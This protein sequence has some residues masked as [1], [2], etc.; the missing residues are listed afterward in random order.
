MLSGKEKVSPL[1][2]NTSVQKAIWP[3]EVWEQSNLTRDATIRSQ[4]RWEKQ[5]K[6]KKSIQPGKF[7]QY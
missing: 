7:L 5:Q 2:P 6:F 4:A 1:L 3:S